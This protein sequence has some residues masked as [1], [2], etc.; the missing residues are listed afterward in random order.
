MDARILLFSNLFELGI[1]FVG[2]D[3]KVDQLKKKGNQAM[4]LKILSVL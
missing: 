1:R 4:K 2:S 3:Y